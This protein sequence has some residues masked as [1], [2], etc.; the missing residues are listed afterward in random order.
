MKTDVL[1]IGGGVIGLSI[2]RN[3]S[4]SVKVAVIEKDLCG[5]HAS[6]K[7]SGVIHAG[8]YYTPGSSKA[9]YS[10][11]GNKKL[12][13]YC[14]EKGIGFENIGKIIA[15]S[16]PEELSKIRELYQRSLLNG[17]PVKIID[18]H[19]AKQ[20]E[21]RIIQQEYYLWSP[22]TSI[23]DNK[24]V[25]AALK[26]D[27]EGQGVKI[28]EGC[29]Y[30]KNVEVPG[31]HMVYTSKEKIFAKFVI[32]CAGAHADTVAQNFGF[33]K[34][35]EILPFVGLY[36]HGKP[37]VEGF[38]TLVYPCPLG[39]N[40]FLGVHT[41]NTTKGVYMLGPTATPAL[42]KE[43]YSVSDFDFYQTLK[44]LRRY[45]LCLLSPY[46][47]FYL[48]LLTQEI[49]K[50]N[51]KNIVADTSKIV[52]GVHLQD[53]LKW[54]PAAV[55]PQVV[56]KSNSEMIGDFIV[57]GDE[58]SIHFI[59]VVSPGWTSALAFTEDIASKIDLSKL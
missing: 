37:G 50:Y 5:S 56:R 15:P 55:Y 21:P 58:K 45:F 47:S 42:W 35:Y 59:N 3:L 14:K 29:K 13:E 49:R 43:Q 30:L 36:L 6:G 19:E 4:K 20:I 33:C 11:L 24:G 1:V 39:K 41:T 31:S 57:E 26:Q 18:Y 32:N 8:I 12:S 51:K 44:S 40:E 16:G 17:A 2:A 27:C 7:N 22:S 54:G 23:A 28:I 10:V 52:T 9:K 25:I 53:Y 48:K 46:R 38:K 34:D